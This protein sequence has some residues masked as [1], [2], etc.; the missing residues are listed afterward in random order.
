MKKEK[1]YQ[2]G[3]WVQFKKQL[4][5]DPE[6]L[7]YLERQEGG[8]GVLTGFR[9]VLD[10]KLDREDGYYMDGGHRVAFV[11]DS[12]YRNPKKIAIQ[13]FFKENP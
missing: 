10:M 12:L 1:D 4:V 3:Q 6:S 2:L 8:Q 7:R 5:K 11:T 9:T 13:H